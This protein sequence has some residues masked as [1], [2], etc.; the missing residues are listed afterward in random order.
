L[1]QCV[2]RYRKR[3]DKTRAEGDLLFQDRV[4]PLWCSPVR[5]RRSP[6]ANA[7]A[8]QSSAIDHGLSA[9]AATIAGNWA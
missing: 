6:A 5:C 3:G 9:H 2:S 4:P 8:M 7:N 1:R